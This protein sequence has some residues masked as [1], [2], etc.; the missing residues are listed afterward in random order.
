MTFFCK[1]EVKKIRHGMR[2]IVKES[3]LLKERSK[4]IDSC[5]ECLILHGVLKDKAMSHLHGYSSGTIWWH[6]EHLMLHV[7]T[8]S[9]MK[10]KANLIY[11]LWNTLKFDAQNALRWLGLHYQNKGSFVDEKSYKP[12]PTTN[13]SQQWSYRLYNG[14]NQAPET[15]ITITVQ[16]KNYRDG[17]LYKRSFLRKNNLFCTKLIGD[18]RKEWHGCAS[19]LKK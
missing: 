9:D 18:M 15:Y 2:G 3:N 11:G 12:N 10:C 7:L 14:I 5:N 1:S 4:V 6:K 17:L 16:S 19:M 13:K 8:T